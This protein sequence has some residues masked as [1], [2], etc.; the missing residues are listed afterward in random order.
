[1][2]NDTGRDLVVDV[3]GVRTDYPAQ[4]LFG[5]GPGAA[6][7]FRVDGRKVARKGRFVLRPGE[8]LERYE[9]GG[10][11]FGDPADRPPDK[12]AEDRRLGLV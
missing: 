11:G 8:T 10:G 6:R 7:E 2:R 4:G 1:M 12:A 5:G 9:A 3:M